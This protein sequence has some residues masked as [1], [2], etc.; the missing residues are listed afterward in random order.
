MVPKNG[1]EKGETE[2]IRR[3]GVMVFLV[4]VSPFILSSL[5][6]FLTINLMDLRYIK[7]V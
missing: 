7:I 2:R 3:D 4:L 1:R 6:L 5:P